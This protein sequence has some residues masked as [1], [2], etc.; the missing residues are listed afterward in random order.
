VDTNS[1]ETASTPLVVI[2]RVKAAV[3]QHLAQAPA[4]VLNGA[5]QAADINPCMPSTTIR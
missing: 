3:A 2:A 5:A 4:E 1:I